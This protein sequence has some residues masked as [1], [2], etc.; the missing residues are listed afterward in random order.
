MVVINYSHDS[1]ISGMNCNL[2]NQLETQ[3]AWFSKRRAEGIVY[4]WENSIVVFMNLGL[5]VLKYKREVQMHPI[6]CVLLEILLI[7]EKD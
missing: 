6:H 1:P 3:I 7:I 5:M 2:K 4:M